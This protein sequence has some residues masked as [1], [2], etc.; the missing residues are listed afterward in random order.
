MPIWYWRFVFVDA[1]GGHG[2]VRRC[3]PLKLFTVHHWR[4]ANRH[5]RRRADVA[6][7]DAAI[8]ELNAHAVG[9]IDRALVTRIDPYSA[10]GRVPVARGMVGLTGFRRQ[11]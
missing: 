10:V 3:P 7:P 9:R 5:R 6:L 8:I 1:N 11:V 2:A 4:A